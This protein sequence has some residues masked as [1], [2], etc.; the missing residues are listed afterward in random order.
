MLREG[1]K[2][3]KAGHCRR[4][5]GLGAFRVVRRGRETETWRDG[6]AETDKDGET[7]TRRGKG[8]HGEIQ[9]ET[10]RQRDR[11]RE[12]RLDAAALSS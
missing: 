8:M 2:L 4:Q 3:E 1:E 9:K 6:Q 12:T 10:S 11:D 5:G 7:D